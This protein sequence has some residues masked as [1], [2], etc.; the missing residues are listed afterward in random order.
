MIVR[1]AQTPEWT[2]VWPLLALFTTRV[3][4]CLLKCLGS[5]GER[6]TV[7]AS[8]GLPISWSWFIHAKSEL[9]VQQICKQSLHDTSQHKLDTFS[10]MSLSHWVPVTAMPLAVS[11]AHAHQF[12]PLILSSERD[13]THWPA[14]APVSRWTFCL[15]FVLHI[16]K[17]LLRFSVPEL[18][19]VEL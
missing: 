4:Y 7:E 11:E 14:K 13:T 2:R 5:K 9:H 18:N 19:V 12:M 10:S 8:R 6:Q 17:T 15:M 16:T 3:C 1:R